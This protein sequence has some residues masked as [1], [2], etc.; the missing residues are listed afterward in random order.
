MISTLTGSTSSVTPRGQPSTPWAPSVRQHATPA[1]KWQNYPPGNTGCTHLKIQRAMSDGKKEMGTEHACACAGQKQGH[2][3][4]RA[5]HD[6]P[7]ACEGRPSAT[8][9]QATGKRAPG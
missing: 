3:P 7:R 4:T 1:K 5:P 2:A 8:K 6:T 9:W